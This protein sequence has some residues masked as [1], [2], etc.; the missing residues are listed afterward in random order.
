MV[1]LSAIFVHYRRASPTDIGT[2]NKAEEIEKGDS[3][4]DVQI[5][6]H[7]ESSFGD[8]VELHERVAVPKT[9]VSNRSEGR[10]GRVLT[11]QS[12]RRLALLPHERFLHV[13]HLR[14]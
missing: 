13:P 5:D 14:G 12:R 3:R 7:A 9:V 4:N 2:I 8:W 1:R 10:K 6:L 11:C